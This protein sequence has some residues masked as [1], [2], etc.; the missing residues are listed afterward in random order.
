MDPTTRSRFSARAAVLKALAHP[1]RLC[2]VDELSRGERCVG[3]LESLVG[4]DIS[5]VSKHLSVLRG[6]GISVLLTP[7]GFVTPR[8]SR[9]STR[10]TRPTAPEALHVELVRASG[11]AGLARRHVADHFRGR[12]VPSVIADAQLVVSELVSNAVEHGVGETLEVEATSDRDSMSLRVRSRCRIR[13]LRRQPLWV[14][15]DPAQVGGRGLPIVGT[16]SS[17]TPTVESAPDGA[18]FNRLTVTAELSADRTD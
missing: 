16:L 11:A 12:V 14:L 5:T 18:W 1:A 9:R 4:L 2:M 6:A 10:A 7:S 15:P 3:D 13:D 8:A 17:V